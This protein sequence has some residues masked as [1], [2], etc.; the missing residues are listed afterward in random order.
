MRRLDLENV[1]FEAEDGPREVDNACQ[2]N[3]LFIADPVGSS[4]TAAIL[5]LPPFVEN[6]HIARCPLQEVPDIPD[7]PSLRLIGIEEAQAEHVGRI[8]TRWS[9]VDLNVTDCPGFDDSVL[10]ILAKPKRDSD[11]RIKKFNAPRLPTLGLRGRCGV[12]SSGLRRMV[13][14]CLPSRHPQHP[15]DDSDLET[16]DAV[17]MHTIRG[18]EVEGLTDMTEEEQAWFSHSSA[19]HINI[20]FSCMFVNPECQSASTCERDGCHDSS[21]DEDLARDSEFHHS[22]TSCNV[23]IPHSNRLRSTTS[24]DSTCISEIFF[25]SCRISHGQELGGCQGT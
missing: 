16:V 1:H 5:C 3:V 6:L 21:R 24:F 12:T 2:L 19:L 18:N 4:L 7:A 17:K 23:A 9:G 14:G 22:S 20:I 11:G 8:F 13:E 25:H 10:N 15:A